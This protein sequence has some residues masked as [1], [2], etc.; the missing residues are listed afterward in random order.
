MGIDIQSMK[1]KPEAQMNEQRTLDKGWVWLV[2][3]RD[4]NSARVVNL[5][6][7]SKNKGHDWHIQGV[8]TSEDLA[9]EMCLDEH[10]VI[11]PLPIDTS[12]PTRRIEW[13]GSYFP[14]ADPIEG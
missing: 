14:L 13:A 1:G 11:G 5:D 3:R 12:L 6:D 4:P 10:Y 7:P 8:T 2:F 9:I